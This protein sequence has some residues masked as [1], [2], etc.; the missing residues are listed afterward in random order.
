MIS[1]LF[2]YR[3]IAF[4]ILFFVF[5]GPL[6]T[7]I[8]GNVRLSESHRNLSN[9]GV[10][11]KTDLLP[12]SLVRYDLDSREGRRLA[13]LTEDWIVEF[14]DSYTPLG[15]E[16][17][18][19]YKKIEEG[20]EIECRLKMD[21]PV[22]R[23]FV[24]DFASVPF[25]VSWLVKPFGAHAEAAVLHDWLYAKGDHDDKSTSTR[26][27]EPGVELLY[28]PKRYDRRDLADIVFFFAIRAS[29]PKC[30]KRE[31]MI[32]RAMCTVSE[33]DA[34]L[35]AHLMFGAVQIWKFATK[36]TV[37]DCQGE[38][39]PQDPLKCA[40]WGRNLNP[41]QEQEG[42]P[43]KKQKDEWRFVDPF[44]GLDLSP[45][46]IEID[47]EMRYVDCAIPQHAISFDTPVHNLD[48]Q[49]IGLGLSEGREI[50][51]GLEAKSDPNILFDDTSN[52]PNRN[53]GEP[54]SSHGLTSRFANNVEILDRAIFSD[55]WMAVF[56]TGENSHHC[57]TG[58]LRAYQERY[59]SEDE[60]MS[61]V[62]PNSD[63]NIR[64]T[65]HKRSLKD[66]LLTGMCQSN[67]TRLIALNELKNA[68]TREAVELKQ[69]LEYIYLCNRNKN[70]SES[71]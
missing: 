45:M 20:K 5:I 18:D 59:R 49:K 1:R 47:G 19:G 40:E 50:N 4:I 58:L 26:S 21:F 13:V 66:H 33:V 53:G 70:A 46:P 3:I 64:P 37:V 17:E 7:I 11:I 67:M 16:C 38:S 48:D 24:S 15:K 56:E 44:T 43:N 52:D 35:R 6:C 30:P 27:S 32:D 71:N 25:F 42:N 61:Q 8:Y 9:S 31:T 10:I 65:D 51:N 62:V 68:G 69:S 23:Y 60:S 63:S 34:S 22:S 57:R 2:F 29:Y 39:S 28:M 54:V 14:T 12:L 41:H 36:N 55:D